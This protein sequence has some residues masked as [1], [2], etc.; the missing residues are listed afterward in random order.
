MIDVLSG[1]PPP[2]YKWY[3]QPADHCM[4]AQSTC[5][6]RSRRWIESVDEVSPPAGVA[7]TRSVISLPPTKRNFFYKVEAVNHMGVDSQVFSVVR[8]G[9]KMTR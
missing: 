8:T 4:A 9:K 6:P 5:K 1:N 2:H 7:S 3:K